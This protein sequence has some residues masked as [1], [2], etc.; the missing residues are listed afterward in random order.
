MQAQKSYLQSQQA[1]ADT[2]DMQFLQVE[3]DRAH[4]KQ[5]EAS[6][7]TLRQILPGVDED[8]LE[9]VLEEGEGLLERSIKTVLEMTNGG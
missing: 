9:W 2:P 1:Q 7:G 3:I 5:S 6:K 8:V 4:E